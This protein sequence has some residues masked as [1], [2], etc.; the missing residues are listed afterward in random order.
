MASRN[1][2]GASIAAAIVFSSLLVS[3]FALVAGT[4]QR[5]H[6]IS[7]AAEEQELYNRAA[8]LEAGSV[9]A[10]LDS[11]QHAVSSRTFSCSGARGQLAGL[12]SDETAAESLDWVSASSSL[13]PG[14]AGTVYDALAG[15][16]PFNGT[17]AGDLSLSAHVVLAGKAPDSSSTLGLEEMHVVS[18]PLRLS[19]LLT[20]CL[21]AYGAASSALTA[22][23]AQIC[24]STALAMV[25]APL[26][27][28]L[29]TGAA[30]SGFTLT[31][32]YGVL[33]SGACG[34]AFAVSVTQSAVAGP[35]GPFSFTAEESGAL[36]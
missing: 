6:L 31:V 9:V 5:F 26:E 10:L 2:V 13:S 4:Q 25:L 12:L 14:P 33:G 34:A 24:N 23:G 18:L 7:V 16:G 1:A 22:M 35:E 8:V 15:V 3:N 11:V 29:R 36:S 28:A 20:T 17:R 27:M 30:E 32:S 21:Q 19:D